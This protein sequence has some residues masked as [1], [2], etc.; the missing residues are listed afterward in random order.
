ML[1]PLPQE[2]LLLE[3]LLPVPPLEPVLL[4]HRLPSRLPRPPLLALL[5]QGFLLLALLGQA[6]LLLVH[7]PR[8]LLSQVLLQLTHLMQAQLPGEHASLQE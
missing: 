8:V 6:A 2:H 1:R 4:V 7:L 5:L 3:P